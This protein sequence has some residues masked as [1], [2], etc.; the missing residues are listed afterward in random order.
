[1]LFKRIRMSDAI[2]TKEDFVRENIDANKSADWELIS[3]S[4]IVREEFKYGMAKFEIVQSYLH[5]IDILGSNGNPNKE[6]KLISMRSVWV[7]FLYLCRQT[8]ELALK[9]TLECMNIT[10]SGPTHD[11]QTLWNLFLEGTANYSSD[12]DKPFLKRISVLIEVINDLDADGSHFR[13]STSN[14]NQLYR[15]KPYIIN[16][17][18]FSDEVHGLVVALMSL[19]YSFW[20]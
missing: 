12:E 7:P 5:A 4:T 1:M 19:D 10:L 11:I 17:K 14:Q 13:Y 16:P 3:A 20:N 15:D 6:L 8:I 2:P 9:N 18:R